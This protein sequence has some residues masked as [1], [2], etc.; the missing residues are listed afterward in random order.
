VL[1]LTSSTRPGVLLGTGKPETDP[2]LGG[3]GKY[4]GPR[5]TATVTAVSANITDH[6][7][8]ITG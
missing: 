5:G 7:L 1:K 8:T 4:Q 3:T 6:V 2:I